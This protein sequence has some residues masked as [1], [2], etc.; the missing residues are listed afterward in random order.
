MTTD[1]DP[2]CLSGHGDDLKQVVLYLKTIE[3][4]YE[5][6][7]TTVNSTYLSRDFAYNRLALQHLVAKPVKVLIKTKSGNKTDVIRRMTDDLVVL[8]NLTESSANSLMNSLMD[9]NRLNFF[10]FVIPEK[11]C[12][13]NQVRFLLYLIKLLY[14]IR[15]T[16][17]I[18][19]LILHIFRSLILHLHLLDYSN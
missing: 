11:V 4:D 14:R 18:Y 9:V 17:N 5:L 12:I 2:T 15:Y 1:Q 19:L 16:S 3:D 7:S 8:G 13:I 10:N 6:V